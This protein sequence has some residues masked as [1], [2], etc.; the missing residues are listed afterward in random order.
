MLALSALPVGGVLIWVNAGSSARAAAESVAKRPPSPGPLV[1]LSSDRVGSI[2]DAPLATSQTT[3]L[4]LAA[5]TATKLPP[6]PLI[7]NRSRAQEEVVVACLELDQP[8]RAARYIEMIDNWR[9][10]TGY[11]DLAF[12]CAKRGETADVQ[13]YLDLAQRI[14]ERVED[15]E[16]GQA[17]RRDRIRTK[18][19]TTYAW[20]GQHEKAAQFEANVTESESGRVAAV[21]AMTADADDFDVQF[22]ALSEI[23]VTGSFDQIQSA[24]EVCAQL[25]NRFYGD[26]DRQSRCEER[27]KASWTKL[28]LPIRIQLLVKL[29]DFSLDHGD[30][31]KALDLLKEAQLMVESFKWTPEHQIPLMTR[32]A[33]C[34][35]RAGDT[36]YARSQTEAALGIFD[37]ERENILIVERAGLLRSVAGTYQSMGDT[38]AA[39]TTYKRAVEEGAQNPNSR[40]RAEDLTATCCSMALHGVEPDT[41]LWARLNQIHDKLADPW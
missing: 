25:F 32:L 13:H 23:V 39:L 9:R 31:S 12:Y 22:N 35:H 40:P 10:G 18:I 29:A 5:K 3:L 19:A 8:Q 20:L 1:P 14:S 4:D 27:I 6:Q 7:K 2:P 34:R 15:D 33:E 36:E 26:P 28:P 24:L 16:T 41:E 37:A 30:Q 21:R 17:W 11:A 38:A